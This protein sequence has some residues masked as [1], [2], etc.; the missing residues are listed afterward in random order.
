MNLAAVRRAWR[1]MRRASCGSALSRSSWPTT[2]AGLSV[3]TDGVES[4]PGIFLACATQE[5]QAAASH[6]FEADHSEGFEA[7]VRQHTVACPIQELQWLRDK[8]SR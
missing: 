1:R 3:C 7:A 5:T 6:G 4:G 2:S 8:H